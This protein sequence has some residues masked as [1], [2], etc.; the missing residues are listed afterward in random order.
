MLTVAFHAAGNVGIAEHDV[1]VAAYDFVGADRGFVKKDGLIA[2]VD[3][4]RRSKRRDRRESERG[5]NEDGRASADAHS[6]AQA[7]GNPRAQHAHRNDDRSENE[8]VGDDDAAGNGGE[9]TH[10]AA[11]AKSRDHAAE[12]TERR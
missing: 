7:L 3:L 4:R 9:R 8:R 2:V 11:F 12:A 6:P 10:V 1:E 5:K